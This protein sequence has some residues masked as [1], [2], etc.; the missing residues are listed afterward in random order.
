MTAAMEGT[1]II[2]N[3]SSIRMTRFPNARRIF[4]KMAFKG[5]VWVGEVAG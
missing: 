3:V 4:M 5:L 1:I 2:M